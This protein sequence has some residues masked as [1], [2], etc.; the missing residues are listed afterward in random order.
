MSRRNEVW[1]EPGGVQSLE[2][3]YGWAGGGEECPTRD[4]LRVCQKY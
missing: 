4:I 2:R 1:H 3:V